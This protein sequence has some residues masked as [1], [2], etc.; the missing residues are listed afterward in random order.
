MHCMLA[1]VSSSLG[2]EYAATILVYFPSIYMSTVVCT[3]A[4]SLLSFITDMLVRT[5]IAIP[6]VFVLVAV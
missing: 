2:A 6:R 3:S 1:I 4:E 5:R